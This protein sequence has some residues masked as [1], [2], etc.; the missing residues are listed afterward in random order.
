MS[1]AKKYWRAVV[2]FGATGSW[3]QN[4]FETKEAALKAA[5][6]VAK[7]RKNLKKTTGYRAER[8]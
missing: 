7:L 2:T 8:E 3:Q 4:G 5:E 1:P 6:G